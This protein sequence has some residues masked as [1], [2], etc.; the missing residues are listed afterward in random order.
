MLRNNN[1]S[2]KTFEE[3]ISEGIMQIPLYSSEWT[4][5]SASDPGITILESLSLFETLQQDRINELTPAVKAALLKMMGF[6]PNKGRNARVLLYAEN[7]K[8]AFVIPKGQRFT[9]E[10]IVFETRK[11]ITI[12][13]CKAT[14]VYGHIDDEWKNYNH[15]LDRDIKLLETVFGKKPKSGSE[16][17][18][19]CNN[20]PESGEEAIFYFDMEESNKR[21]NFEEKEYN[22]FAS[23]KWEVYGENGFTE[24][25]AYDRTGGFLTSGEVLFRFPEYRAVPF[26]ERGYVI[27]AVLEKADYDIAPVMKGV[28]AFLFE[29]WQQHTESVSY[30]GRKVSSIETPASLANNHYISVF[31]REDDSGF[32][33]HYEL[34]SERGSRGRYFSVKEEGDTLIYKFDKRRFGY[35]PERGN[36][37]VRVVA[38]SPEIMSR[39]HIGMVEGYD[40]QIIN[41]PVKNVIA[42]SFFIIARLIDED[43]EKY[44][45]FVRPGHNRDG[46]L[47]Y[48]LFEREGYIMIKEAGDFLGAELFMGGCATYLGE[49]GN[50]RAGNYLKAIDLKSGEDVSHIRFYNP[51]AGTGGRFIESLE[52]VRKRFVKDIDTPFSAVTA[53]DYEMIVLDT[54]GL[55]LRKAKAY[56]D[57]SRNEVKIAILPGNEGNDGM[58]FLTEEY[59]NVIKKRLEERRLL[60]TKITLMKPRYERVNVKAVVYVDQYFEKNRQRIERRINR[61]INYL[62]CSKNFGDPL[63]FEE[64]FEAIE[65]DPGVEFVSKL[66][67][68]PN[69]LQYAAVKEE[70]IYPNEDVILIP[71]NVSVEL[72]PY[73]KSLQ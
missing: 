51:C 55:C 17:Y 72:I 49:E 25:N 56:I 11:D 5:Y 67:L 61:V 58:P 22:L 27:R 40:D 37:A 30:T 54:P 1:L 29:V 4:N 44:Y 70:S 35:G 45:S 41:L 2:D 60:T 19:F 33:R 57:Q 71:G 15:L 59:M 9:L 47:Y 16:L 68:S 36:A 34:V 62:E 14:A 73:Y 39:Y 69:R 38:Y 21:N 12:N 46:E 32:Y 53:S 43:G 31:V 42:D 66:K 48:R 20:L 63:L 64:V 23:V 65:E 50:I 8:E 13:D 24:L 28:Y 52:D 3:R 18:F 26:D 10:N 7:V 6:K